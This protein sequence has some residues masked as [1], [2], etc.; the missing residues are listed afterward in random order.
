MCV[1]AYHF[2]VGAFFIKS[3]AKSG[4]HVFKQKRGEDF[5]IRTPI[6]ENGNFQSFRNLTEFNA[7]LLHFV[8]SW[9]YS[10]VG[11]SQDIDFYLYILVHFCHM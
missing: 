8:D 7:W 10:Q 4:S 11:L 2:V 5:I 1:V 9:S 3:L 6:R